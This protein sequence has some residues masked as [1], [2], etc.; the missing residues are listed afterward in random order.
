VLKNSGPA[1]LQEFRRDNLDVSG[2]VDTL[3]ALFLQIR[4]GTVNVRAFLVGLVQF[5]SKKSGQ[6]SVVKI[7]DNRRVLCIDIIL[8]S[9]LWAQRKCKRGA[10]VKFRK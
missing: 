6:V 8:V 3:S 10:A 4:A 7:P 9:Y 1:D 5:V 2:Q